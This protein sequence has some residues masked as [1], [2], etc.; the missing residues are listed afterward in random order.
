MDVGLSCGTYNGDLGPDLGALVWD[1]GE[2]DYICFE[3]HP[4]CFAE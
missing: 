2:A 1:D 3:A 4:T